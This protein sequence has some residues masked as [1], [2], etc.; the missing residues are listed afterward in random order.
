MKKCPSCHANCIPLWRAFVMPAFAPAFECPCCKTKIA[1]KSGATDYVA[2]I[3]LIAAMGYI[4]S[5]EKFTT[6]E[7]WTLYA[8]A[9]V[10]GIAAW[11]PFIRYRIF[12]T[13]LQPM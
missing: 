11:L 1:R 12:P 10:L 4:Y 2:F 7:V 9:Y 5:G 6:N 3:P 8:A 13:E